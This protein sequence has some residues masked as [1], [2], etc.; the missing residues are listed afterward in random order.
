MSRRT[1]VRR[2]K[3]AIGESPLTFQQNLRVEAA[4]RLMETEMYSFDEITYRI[5]YEDSSTFRKIFSRHTG[6]VPSNQGVTP[7]PHRLVA[8]KKAFD[9][10]VRMGAVIEPVVEVRGHPGLRLAR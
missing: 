5:G 8:G 7:F 1:L 10:Q 6:L 4:Y 3:A 2:F 9:L